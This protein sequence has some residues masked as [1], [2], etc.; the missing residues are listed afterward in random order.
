MTPSPDFKYIN[1][2]LS[3]PPVYSSDFLKKHPPMDRTH[4]AKLFA[5]FAALDG[6]TATI[7]SKD[8]VYTPET[9]L[10]EEQQAVLEGK[11]SL[12]AELTKTGTAARENRIVVTVTY[13]GPCQ[14][15]YSDAY[16]NGE[17]IYRE[18]TGIVWLVNQTERTV[19]IGECEVRFDQIRSISGK[20]FDESAFREDY[21]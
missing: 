15:I 14:D 16:Q 5:P 8:T 6:M 20:V 11:L 19:L 9:L 12:L 2:F 1:A 7:N 10:S 13:F 4:R 21:G 3:G 17:G 18:V